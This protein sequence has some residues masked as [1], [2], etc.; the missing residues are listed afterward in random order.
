[1][2]RQS[3]R[4]IVASIMAIL[5]VVWIGSLA[6]IYGS[7]YAEMNRHNRE[8]L[9]SYTQIYDPYR[10][11]DEHMPKGPFPDEKGDMRFRLSTF[12][13]VA[14]SLEG[15]VISTEVPERS[16]YTEEEIISTAKSIVSNNQTKGKTDNLT[17]CV[18]YTE[19]YTLV[20]FMDNTMAND[21]VSTLLR[22]T[23]IFGAIALIVFFFVAEHLADRIIKPLEETYEK[24]KQFISDAGHELKTPVS[25]VNANAE[26]L[27]REIGEN[28]WLSNIQYENERMGNLVSQLLDLAR[29]ENVE[30]VKEE[31][32]F[33][34]IVSGEALPFESVAF[35][36][37]ITLETDVESDVK[38]LGNSAQ[39]KQVVSILIDNA[40]RHCTGDK[41]SV[42]LKKDHGQ[43]V[44]SVENEGD[45]IPKEQREKIFER[46]YRA[47]E[48][49]TD[50]AGNY[51]LGLAIAKSVAQAHGGSIN[52]ECENGLVKFIF[53]I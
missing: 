7:S 29:L 11:G 32:D 6:V 13:A 39:L 2:F 21:N 19:Q 8:M 35:E 14:I 34:R 52:V 10:S 12:Y 37:G 33:S 22:Y 42:A 27:S 5:V 50:D 40:L 23:F 4:K 36:K 9:A 28:Q 15:D 41:V 1:M 53:R 26:I 31:T 30:T 3:K 16:A 20:A 25:V 49:R 18:T 47:D 46:F 45:E 44:L 38:V 17:Y 48:A 51:G 43:A 24:Q